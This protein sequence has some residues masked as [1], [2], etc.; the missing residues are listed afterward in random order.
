[1][2]QLRMVDGKRAIVVES[3]TKD[4]DIVLLKHD[5]VNIMKKNVAEG[6][7]KPLCVV[8]VFLSFPA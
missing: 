6:V 8:V 4:P 1:M 5:I 3:R 2:S 7:W